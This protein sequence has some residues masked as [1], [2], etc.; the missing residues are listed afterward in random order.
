MVHTTV[1]SITNT[2]PPKITV[3]RKKTPADIRATIQGL[4]D[5][6]GYDP[7]REMI[8]LA[9]ETVETEVNGV[10]VKLPVCDIDQKIQI[11]KEIASYMAPKLKGIEIAGEV[12]HNFTMR[13][14]HFTEEG[15]SITVPA[16]VEEIVVPRIA[17]IEDKEE[18]EPEPVVTVKEPLA[19]NNYT[20]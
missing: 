7:F 4:C 1:F 12:D 6:A 10:M 2:V 5:E 17:Q 9:T 18:D 20:V 13:I 19:R 3:K 14:L 8:R 16:K 11:A 15:K